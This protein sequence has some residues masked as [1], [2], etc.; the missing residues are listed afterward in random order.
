MMQ[1]FSALLMTDGRRL[2]MEFDPERPYNEA[3][4]QW[5]WRAT[6]Q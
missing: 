1:Q 6:L 3:W 2:L 4:G 5:V